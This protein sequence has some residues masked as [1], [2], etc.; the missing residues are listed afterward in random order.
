MEAKGLPW[1]AVDVQFVVN[2]KVDVALVIAAVAGLIGVLRGSRSLGLIIRSLDR[3]TRYQLPGS[4]E[5]PQ[6]PPAIE[7]AF[8]DQKDGATGD[9]AWVDEEWAS[10]SEPDQ[11]PS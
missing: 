6:V 11:D 1:L 3:D 7:A 8:K 9:R 4:D 2:V 10:T 5:A